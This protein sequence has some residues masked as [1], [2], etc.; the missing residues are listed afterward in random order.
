LAAAMSDEAGSIASRNGSASRASPFNAVRRG[1]DF[2]SN[3]ISAVSLSETWDSR[4][5][6]DERRPA[7]LLAAASRTIFLTAGRS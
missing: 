6:E 4:Q 5:S 7:V 2:D 1:N 3:V